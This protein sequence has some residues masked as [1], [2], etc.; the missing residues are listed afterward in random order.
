MFIAVEFCKTIHENKQLLREVIDSP[1]FGLSPGIS[2]A[3]ASTNATHYETDIKC[4]VFVSAE[5]KPDCRSSS[6]DIPLLIDLD[7]LTGHVPACRTE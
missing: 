4:F 3:L 6:S 7:R 1:W 5:N 2:T